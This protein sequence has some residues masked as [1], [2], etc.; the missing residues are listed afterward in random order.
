LDVLEAKMT[1]NAQYF[2]KIRSFY[3]KKTFKRE[4]SR[5]VKQ[6]EKTP[7][8]VVVRCLANGRVY[9]GRSMDVRRAV[10]KWRSYIRTG[11]TNIKA[12]DA[13]I[14]QYGMDQFSVTA[15]EV[16]QNCPEEFVRL[17][18]DILFR[19]YVKN[20]PH[21]Y[22]KFEVI[23]RYLPL[24]ERARYT[25]LGGTTGRNQQ[26]VDRTTEIK[27][28]VVY[29]VTNT[30]TKKRLV[31]GVNDFETSWF[32]LHRQ[33]RQG[34]FRDAELQADWTTYGEESF[35][36]DFYRVDSAD[37]RKIKALVLRSFTDVYGNR[38]KQG[39]RRVVADGGEL[40]G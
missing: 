5:W 23:D 4:G 9:F 35:V 30:V 6:Y 33:L 19:G 38:R 27:G 21:I 37:L 28:A 31:C 14:A 24:F 10:G 29:V 25:A 18:L 26:Q 13:D 1:K 11:K 20:N 12:I 32:A 7:G 17:R 8:I 3:A 22:N 34:T 39:R 15:G 16:V 40:A 2:S 36:A